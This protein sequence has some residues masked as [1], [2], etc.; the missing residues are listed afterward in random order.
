MIFIIKIILL[1]NSKFRANVRINNAVIIMI[2]LLILA[3]KV[4]I[5]FRYEI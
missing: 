1:G 4:A 3:T 5:I 2:L